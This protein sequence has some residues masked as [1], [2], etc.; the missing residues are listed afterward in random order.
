MR[1]GAGEGE[2]T[3]EEPQTIPYNSLGTE[4]QAD[5]DPLAIP[6]EFRESRQADS[7]G[8]AP[9]SKPQ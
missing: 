5:A 9:G 4:A 7:S 3:G 6:E 1:P 2:Y 8:V